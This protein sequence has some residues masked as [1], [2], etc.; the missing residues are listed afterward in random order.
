MICGIMLVMY[1]P[2]F[3]ITPEINNRIAEIERIREVIK[4]SS[5][6]PQQEVVLRLRAKINSIYSSTSI[7][8]NLLNR[9]EVEKV[10]GGERVRASEKMIIE[11][12][13]YKKAI[14]WIEKR[15][16]SINQ[17]KIGDILKLHDFLM[18]NLLPHKKTGSFRKGSIYVVDATKQGDVVKY[19]GPR[20]EKTEAL[21]KELLEWLKKE[22]NKLHPVLTAGLFHYEFVSIH[23]FSDGNGR[24]TR[25]LTMMYLWLKRYDFRKTLALDTYYWQNRMDY[26]QA[27]SRAKT[28]TGRREAD[29]TP[30]LEFFTKGFLAAAK[31]LE[32]EITSV[33]LSDNGQVIRL[34][35]DELLIIDFAKQMKRI[36]LQDVLK[37]LGSPGRTAQRRLKRLVDNKIFKRLGKGKSIYY[38]LVKND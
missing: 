24:A 35:N 33:S 21:I 16:G 32:N 17:I 14:D 7:E 31:D 9:R 5:I 23:P 26:Y 30:W 10:L 12:L 4:K 22:R 38:Q 27:L 15:L 18:K 25:L 36:N 1:K 2:N 6:L 19:V 20:G 8:G 37:I 11:A 28:Y 13:N 34:S 29:I 3:K